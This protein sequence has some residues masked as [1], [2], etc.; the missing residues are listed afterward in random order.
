MNKNQNKI[1]VTTQKKNYTGLNK[2]KKNAK[3]NKAY[4]HSLKKKNLNPL[5]N[6]INDENCT[7]TFKSNDIVFPKGKNLINS[8]INYINNI[9]NY[10][11]ITNINLKI[12]KH[13]LVRPGPG[14]AFIDQGQASVTQLKNFVKKSKEIK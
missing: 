10:N 2:N 4:Y 5:F 11:N 1:E 12:P 8:K 9:N 3:E 7:V 6:A 14:P 13:G